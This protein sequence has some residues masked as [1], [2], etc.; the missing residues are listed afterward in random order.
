MGG[1]AGVAMGLLLQKV[2]P[3]GSPLLA[4]VLM[5]AAAM[6]AGGLLIAFVGMLRHWRGQ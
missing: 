6:T 4:Q 1:L 2:Y 5:A 3:E